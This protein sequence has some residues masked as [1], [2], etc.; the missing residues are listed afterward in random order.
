MKHTATA[1]L[2]PHLEESGTCRQTRKC[3]SAW[4]PPAPNRSCL[5]H[6]AVKV[7]FSAVFPPCVSVHSCVSKTREVIPF[8]LFRFIHRRCYWCTAAPW[9]T[10][11][12]KPARLWREEKTPGACCYWDV[13]ELMKSSK[14]SEN[15]HHERASW[16]R[17]S[18]SQNTTS[19]VSKQEKINIYCDFHVHRYRWAK[20]QTP[21]LSCWY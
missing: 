20:Y 16:A 15:V 2:D 11:H 10:A 3:R 7:F 8:L 12:H 14:G 21:A 13:W 17:V 9:L 5:F 1:A 6:A 19:M 18:W 4:K